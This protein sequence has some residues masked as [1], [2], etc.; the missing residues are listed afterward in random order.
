[1]VYKSV[2][3]AAFIALAI[4]IFAVGILAPRLPQEV[5]RPGVQELRT[6]TIPA[7][8]AFRVQNSDGTVRVNAGTGEEIEVTA[9][10]RA[11]TMTTAMDAIATQYLSS[12]F[13][14][15]TD[16]GMVSLVTE[17]V[18][19][20]DELDLRVDYTITLPA[21]SDVAVEVSNGNVWIDQGFSQITVEGN[22]S[23]IEIV[24][25]EGPVLA[26]ST[27][28]RIRLLEANAETTLETVNG[29]IQVGVHG[30]TLQ[31]STITGMINASLT[32]AGVKACDLTS[33]NGGITLVMPE[34]FSAEI[35]A[36]TGRGNVRVDPVLQFS[37][38]VSKRRTLLG[39]TGDGATKLSL[40][41][42]NGDIV[43]QRSAS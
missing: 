30:G 15:K 33:L 16:A 12:L 29:N 26:K 13:Q 35:S 39:V 6:F 18:E 14:I 10:I 27:N 34:S 9:D 36:T 24:R 3:T 32:D 4:Q 41:S 37:K 11:Y 21:G 23:D 43:L 7:A 20:P 1:M 17:P 2:A 28:G 19:R 40:N 5:C 38:G 25:S 42:M 31:A 22:N 8:P